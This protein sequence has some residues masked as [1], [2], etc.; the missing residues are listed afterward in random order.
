M[1]DP[2]DNFTKVT[3]QP[4]SSKNYPTWSVLTQEIL[5][6]EELLELL[7][8]DAPNPEVSSAAPV[9]RFKKRDR[10]AR[11]YI[12]LHLGTEAITNFTSILASDATATD[13][14][15]RLKSIYQREKPSSKY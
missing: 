13:V 15:T 8:E 14:W 9:T 6:R 11:Y 5:H 3:I 10:K 7:S 1:S 12:V 2:T 4:L